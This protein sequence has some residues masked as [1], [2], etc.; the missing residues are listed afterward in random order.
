MAAIEQGEHNP[1]L[2]GIVNGII[3]RYGRLL[4]NQAMAMLDNALYDGL[5]QGRGA[6]Q[7]YMNNWVERFQDEL[8]DETHR[9]IES[10]QESIANTPDLIQGAVGHAADWLSNVGPGEAIFT[11]TGALSG[12][13]LGGPGGAAA[14]AYLGG[15]VA[16]LPGMQTRTREV[17]IDSEG[18]I[19]DL[20]DLIPQNT[21]SEARGTVRPATGPPEGQPEAQRVA[22]AAGG[23]AGNPVSKETPISPYP[24]LTYGLQETH[25]TILPWCGYISTTGMTHGV[26]NVLNLR[27]TQPHDMVATTIQGLAAGG[28]W[29]KDFYNVPYND[30]AT[31]DTAL[32][33]EF[34]CTMDTGAANTEVPSWWNWWKTQYEYYTVLGCEYEILINNPGSQPGTEVTVGW[35]TNSY[36]DTSGASGNITP[37]NQTLAIMKQWKGLQW[38]TVNIA[39]NDN[40]K[41]NEVMIKG[42]YKPGQA[43]RNIQNDGDVK[44]WIATNNGGTPAA[45]TLKEFLTLYFYRGELAYFKPASRTLGVNMQIRLKYIVQFKDLRRNL[46]YPNTSD[47]TITVTADGDCMQFP[48]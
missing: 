44:T 31:R 27:M 29:A 10:V 41:D 25:T 26:P 38:R 20:G 40:G 7:R 8:G 2:Q 24:T 28:T 43:R 30:A 18:D 32:A 23:G 33:A 16:R 12:A 6:L 42:T 37:D 13:I 39:S 36:S 21:M 17:T 5:E 47:G 14:G 11:G 45:P 4:S 34:P 1:A 9:I 19:P 48:I 22:S 35:D 15:A 46:R 3:G